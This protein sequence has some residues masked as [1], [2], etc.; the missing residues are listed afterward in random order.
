M[1]ST[2]QHTRWCDY[3]S[4]KDEHDAVSD[5]ACMTVPESVQ[6]SLRQP[7]PGLEAADRNVSVA[8]TQYPDEPIVVDIGHG[9]HVAFSLT[10]DEAEEIASMILRVVARTHTHPEE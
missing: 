1:T 10:V 7:V 9:P 6:L 3:T 8:L 5:P 4:G 2:L